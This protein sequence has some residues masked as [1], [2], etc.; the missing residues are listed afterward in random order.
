MKPFESGT[1]VRRTETGEIGTVSEQF[2][3]GYVSLV[4]DDGRP[5][6]LLASSLEAL[7]G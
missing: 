1:R 7:S 4:F 6:E 5:A 3:D 2:I